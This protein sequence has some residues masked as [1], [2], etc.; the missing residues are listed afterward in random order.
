MGV[1]YDSLGSIFRFIIAY[2]LIGIIGDILVN[3]MKSFMEISQKWKDSHITAVYFFFSFLVNLCIISF[4]N[5]F[6][7]SIEI[8][9]WTQVVLAGILAL[10]DILFD[11]DKE[12]KEVLK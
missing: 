1:Q 8:A 4:L 7:N 3:V 10:L 6:M 2:F 11:N 12:K 9:L 5:R